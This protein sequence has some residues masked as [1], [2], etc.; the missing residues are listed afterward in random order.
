MPERDHW[1]EDL[2]D[3]LGAAYDRYAH[4]KGTVQEVDHVVAQLG[5]EPGSRVLDVGCGTG[6]HAREL[7]RRGVVV[8]GI[9]ISERFVELAGDGAPDGATF[10]RLDA[11]A[12]AFDDEFD[13][14]ICLC[15][16]AFGMM[17]ADGDDGLVVAGMAQALRDDG[18]LA[19]SAF[20]AYFAVRY[21]EAASSTRRPACRTSA[22]RSV[23]NRARSPPS[24]SGPAATRHANCACCCTP[25]TSGSIRSSSVEPGA[26][27]LAPADGRIA[28]I[29][30]VATRSPERCCRSRAE[31]DICNISTTASARH[32]PSRT[33]W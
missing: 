23:P 21:H 19:L 4:T 15:Q 14:V 28:R 5:L 30:R 24:T 6:R 17:T 13:A 11:R 26:Y 32:P 10:D 9:D 2:A 12:M 25:T 31:R 7:A 22:P 33:R 20:N 27:A 1:F 16:G 3:H 18:R 8:H 29:P